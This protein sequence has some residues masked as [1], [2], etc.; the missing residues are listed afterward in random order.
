[1]GSICISSQLGEKF[2]LLRSNQDIID[3]FNLFGI[4]MYIV[5][6]RWLYVRLFKFNHL[7]DIT[8][9]YHHNLAKSL[10]CYVMTPTSSTFSIYLCIWS[11]IGDFICD[12]SRFLKDITPVYHHNL[13]RGLHCYVTTR[14]SL[15]FSIYLCAMYIV[16]NRWLYVWLFEFNYLMDI[17]PAQ[18]HN[19][20]K[21]LYDYVT[22][23]T[24]ST[25]SI[26]LGVS[27][28]KGDLVCDWPVQV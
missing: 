15:T 8:P 21:S 22:T 26:Y 19:S 25:F 4:H 7:K 10:H 27:S 3:L 24:S 20:V 2:I 28:V 11:I 1:M 9:V 14:T 13:A 17:T 6:N 18:Y 16:Y 5:Y 12:C 23:R